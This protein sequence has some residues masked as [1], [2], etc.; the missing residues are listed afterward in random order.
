MAVDL[1]NSGGWDKSAKAL[2]RLERPSA[3]MLRSLDTGRIFL[4]FSVNA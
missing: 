1:G 4:Y 3:G 2:A